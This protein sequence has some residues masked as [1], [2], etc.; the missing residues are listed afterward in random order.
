MKRIYKFS[1][2]P[3]IGPVKVLVLECDLVCHLEKP[4]EV[5][6]GK[7]SV[8]KDCSLRIWDYYPAINKEL[9]SDD[10]ECYFQIITLTPIGQVKSIQGYEMSLE[11]EET[12]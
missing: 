8:L 4:S 1:V 5:F 10:W 12:E 7:L 6:S 9:S 2:K 11:R 3:E